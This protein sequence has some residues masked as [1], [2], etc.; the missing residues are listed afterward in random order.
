MTFKVTKAGSI[1]AHLYIQYNNS[2]YGT[3]KHALFMDKKKGHKKQT[4][5]KTE[6]NKHPAKHNPQLTLIQQNAME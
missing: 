4:G 1:V 2:I 6:Q 3:A 5:R